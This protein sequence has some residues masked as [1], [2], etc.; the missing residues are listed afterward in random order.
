M[1]L[2]RSLIICVW[3]LEERNRVSEADAMQEMQGLTVTHRLK[4]KLLDFV[5]TSRLN[6]T[7][8]SKDANYRLITP[9]IP[10][11]CQPPALRDLI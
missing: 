1:R 2:T 9:L 3:A 4:I 8:A 10:K 5:R 7:K 11:R 6:E